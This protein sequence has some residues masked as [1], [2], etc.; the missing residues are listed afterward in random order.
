DGPVGDP[1]GLL[2]H[3]VHTGRVRAAQAGAAI[4][5]GQ[6]DEVG[7]ARPAPRG[8]RVLPRGAALRWRAVRRV[9]AVE[10]G[11]G[12]PLVVEQRLPLPDHAEVAVVDD[13]DLDWD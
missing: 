11:V 8:D 9:A 6:L 3:R 2:D 5:L 12:I 13:G 7:D 10:V 4:R 1:H